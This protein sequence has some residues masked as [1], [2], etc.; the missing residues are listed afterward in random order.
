MGSPWLRPFGI[1]LARP[2]VWNL[3]RRSAA[4]GVAVGL[5]TGLLPGPTQIV[6]AALVSVLLRAN[7]PTAVLTTLYTNPLTIVPLYML[8]YQ[9]G[10]RVTGEQG[11][12]PP[13]PPL[14]LTSLGNFIDEWGQWVWSLGDTL[15]VGL[16]L[17]GWLFACVGYLVVIFAWRCAVLRRWRARR[18][19]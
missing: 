12:M 1:A 11:G 19:G 3:N 14:D 4:L 17:Q 2:G 5:F 10:A 16:A 7:L 18:S 13:V 15:L 6:S 8:A 9:I